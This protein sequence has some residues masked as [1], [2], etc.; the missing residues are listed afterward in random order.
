LKTHFRIFVR[1]ETEH[2]V[3][4]MQQKAG[5]AIFRAYLFDSLRHVHAC[6][7]TPSYE[8]YPLYTTPARDDEEGS[9][10]EEIRCAEDNG[11]VIYIHVRSLDAVDEGSF[12][13]CGEQ[14]WPDCDD[15]DEVRESVEEHYKANVAIQLPKGFHHVAAT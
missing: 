12:Y 9:V 8:L 4:E 6:E 2:W 15:W 5:G 11:E 10:E 13:D 1:N 14:T 7:L 3:E